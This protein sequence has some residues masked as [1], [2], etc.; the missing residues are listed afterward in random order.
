MGSCGSGPWS[1]CSIPGTLVRPSPASC[2]PLLPVPGLYTL[3]QFLRHTPGTLACSFLSP[4]LDMEYKAA[5]PS[6]TSLL[7]ILSGTRAPFGFKGF[8]ANHYRQSKNGG[9]IV[10]RVPITPLEVYNLRLPLC[11][12]HLPPLSRL[13]SL[14]VPQA[15]C[16]TLLPTPDLEPQRAERPWVFE[17]RLQ[18][19]PVEDTKRRRKETRAPLA[20]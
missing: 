4:S 11:T 6:P 1:F 12:P 20:I 7:P 16:N 2:N 5:P 3:P 18:R 9:C 19:G 13:D 15:I 10:G 14:A 8:I 17:K